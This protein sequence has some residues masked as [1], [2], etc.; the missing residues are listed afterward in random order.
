MR[1]IFGRKIL[2]LGLLVLSAAATILF[3]SAVTINKTRGVNPL[4]PYLPLPDSGGRPEETLRLEGKTIFDEGIYKL[5]V[6]A[7]PGYVV[8][9][10]FTSSDL[11]VGTE[12]KLGERIIVLGHWDNTQTSIFIVESII[13]DR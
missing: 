10:R 1:I 11:K 7:L 5:E 12:A 3:G 4:P 8:P 9:L 6:T 2:L 13:S